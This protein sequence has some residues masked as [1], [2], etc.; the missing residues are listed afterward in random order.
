MSENMLV[1][2]FSV[3]ASF[4]ECLLFAQRSEALEIFE[5]AARHFT[6][7]LEIDYMVIRMNGKPRFVRIKPR[8]ASSVSTCPLHWRS[9]YVAT[10]RG[11]HKVVINHS[12]FL[13][14]ITKIN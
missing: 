13:A 2:N 6:L 4:A 3:V 10:I 9:I 5:G 12:N 8:K 1:Y 11:R 14:L 7:K